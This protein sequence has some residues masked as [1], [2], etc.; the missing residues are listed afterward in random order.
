MHT[1]ADL[2]KAARVALGLSPEELAKEA[3][4]SRRSLSRLEA[5]SDTV[6]LRILLAVQR[7]LESRGVV[8][9]AGDHTQGPG[10]RLPV[11]RSSDVA[12]N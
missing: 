12:T 10:F 4:I 11:R 7:T 6:A 8:F 9:L 1:P 5:G 2:L 3:G